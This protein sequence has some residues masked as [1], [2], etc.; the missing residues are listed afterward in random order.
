MSVNV[1]QLAICVILCE[2]AGVLGSIPNIKSIPRWFSKIRKPRFQPP[3]WVFGPVWTLLYLLMGVSLYLVV[4]SAGWSSVAVLVFFL[5]LILNLAWSW[6]FF[7]LKKPGF[8][9]FELAVLWIVIMWNIAV[10]YPISHGASYLL[11]PY[12][13]WVSFAAVLNYSIW[14]LNR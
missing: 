9:F 12:I 13:L 5:Q 1:F 10:F 3:N 2:L 7:G 8:A 4:G 6:I 14:R 11:A